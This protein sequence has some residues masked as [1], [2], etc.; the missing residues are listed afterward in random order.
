MVAD[1]D[2]VK[3]DDRELFEVRRVRESVWWMP[4]EPTRQPV[5]SATP[6]SSNVTRRG[7]Q[8]GS[9][10]ASGGV[11]CRRLRW[12]DP[13]LVSAQTAKELLRSAS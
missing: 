11:I 5:H 4:E 13:R 9:C 10:G 12:G 3:P 2:D 7:V 1:T 8:V 6:A